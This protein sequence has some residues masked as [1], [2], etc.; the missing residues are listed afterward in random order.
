MIIA[1]IDQVPSEAELG[2][3]QEERRSVQDEP[4]PN[5][6]EVCGTPYTVDSGDGLAEVVQDCEYH[7]YDDYCDYTVIEWGVVDTFVLS[8]ADFNPQ[9]PEPVLVA[10]QR[11]GDDRS[12]QYVIV[13]DTGDKTYTYT[14]TDLELFKQAQLGS[15]WT[16]NINTFGGVQSIER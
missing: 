5:A 14:T 9:W 16:L 1:T 13:F 11:L 6:L 4:A 8:G 10:D 3:C 12:E 15:T 7:V 2:A